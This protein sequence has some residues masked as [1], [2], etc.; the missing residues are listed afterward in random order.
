MK[1]RLYLLLDLDRLRTRLLE[2]YGYRDS[3][4]AIPAIKAETGF[5]IVVPVREAAWAHEI[6]AALES[7]ASHC[8]SDTPE[9]RMARDQIAIVHNCPKP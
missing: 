8:G 6:F 9:L 2:D 4:T 5:P 3:A 7:L 1:T